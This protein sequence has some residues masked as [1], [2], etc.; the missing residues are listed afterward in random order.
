MKRRVLLGYSLGCV[1][2]GFIAT[3]CQARPPAATVVSP[4]PTPT[5]PAATTTRPE[6]SPTSAMTQRATPSP[7]LLRSPRDVLYVRD[8]YG[9]VGPGQ[10][11]VVDAVRGQRVRSL[12]LGIWPRDWSALY[13]TEWSGGKTLLKSVDP[14]TGETIHQTTVDGTFDAAGLSP[15]GRWLALQREVSR[16]EATAFTKSGP[17]QSHFQIVDRTLGSAKLIGLDGNF[18]FD[19]VSDDGKALY[20]IE[21]VSLDPPTRYQVRVYDVPRNQLQPG[22]IADKTGSRVMQGFRQ[23]SVFSPDG[24][25]LYSLYLNQVK[26]PFIHAL[27]LAQRYAVCLDLPS[28]GKDDFERRLLWSTAMSPNGAALYAANGSLGLAAALD[29]T[30]LRVIRTGNFP[31]AAAAAPSIVARLSNWLAPAAE[32]KRLLVGGAALSPDGQT[33]YAIADKGL[34][35]IDTASLSPRGHLLKD[36]LL[37]SIALDPTGARLYA[38]DAQLATILALDPSTGET[39]ATIH[40]ADHPA[41]ILRVAGPASG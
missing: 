13:A 24:T 14:G 17:W 10:I 19:A 18:W 40:G 20:L 12:P 41:G 30:Q 15:N 29:L 37:D 6:V 34:L 26:G 3:A 27:N 28:E 23:S 38:V 22:P 16:D 25:W 36:W 11:A 4:A 31:V 33:L 8:N 9:V 21:N 32:A 5:S 7:N 2:T 35:A 39:L 1:T